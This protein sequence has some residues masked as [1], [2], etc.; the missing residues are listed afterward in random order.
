VIEILKRTPHFVAT[1]D[2]TMKLVRYTRTSTPFVDAAEIDATLA[3]LGSLAKIERSCF[4]LLLDLREG[5]LRNVEEVEAAL[6]KHRERMFGGYAGIAI[7]VR[8]AVGKLQVQRVRRKDPVQGNVFQD[9]VAALAYLRTI[10][11]RG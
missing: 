5:P 6:A 7:L 8:S 9:E 3:D 1:A 11:V 10:E 4:R 2:H